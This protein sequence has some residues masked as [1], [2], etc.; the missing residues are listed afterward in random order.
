MTVPFPGPGEFGVFGIVAL[1]G[2]LVWLAFVIGLVVLVVLGIR[3]LLRST[4]AG[5]QMTGTQ[6]RNLAD[7]SAMAALRERFARG[8]IDAQEFEERRRV[9][10]G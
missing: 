3:W 2:M 10:G 7:D 9:L 8:E 1:V 5:R 4:A 6:G